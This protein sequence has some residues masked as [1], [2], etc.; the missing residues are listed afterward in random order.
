MGREHL[1]PA[2]GDLDGDGDKDVLVGTREGKLYFYENVPRKRDSDEPYLLELHPDPIVIGRKVVPSGE[3]I[4]PVL[5]DLD[6][7][8]V[9]DLLIGAFDGRV[10]VSRNSGTKS[11]WQFDEP[12]AIKGIDNMKPR[13]VP[14]GKWNVYPRNY[15]NAA[16]ILTAKKDEGGRTYA[17]LSFADGY[18]DGDAG[19]IK[20]GG[21]TF[22]F[23]TRYTMTFSARG[24][25][26]KPVCMLKQAGETVVVGGDTRETKFGGG[27]AYEFSVGQEWSEY[28]FSFSLPRLTA[29]TEEQKTT[30]ASVVFEVNEAQPGGYLDIT[31]IT[32]RTQ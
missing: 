29:V 15:R 21:V 25:G 12:I 24:K 6:S 7:D 31:D 26:I 4:R 23:D 30:W 14:E 27:A 2:I 1:V 20:D 8:G 18:C 11:A 28:R 17:R 16:V 22:N 3:V 13:L 9:L 19:L 10:Y 5:V 32:F